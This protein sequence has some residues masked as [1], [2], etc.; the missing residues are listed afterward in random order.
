MAIVG[1]LLR[2]QWAADE[3]ER[4]HPERAAERI[5]YREAAEQAFAEMKVKFPVLTGEN[6]AE[7]DKFCKTRTQELLTRKTQGGL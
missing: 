6:F 7:A 4:R 1:R 5:R 2:K 3:A